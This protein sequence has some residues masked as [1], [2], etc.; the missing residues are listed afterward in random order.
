MFTQPVFLSDVPKQL[1]WFSPLWIPIFGCSGF[2]LGLIFYYVLFAIKHSDQTLLGP[3][4]PES[5]TRFTAQ[6]I[7]NMSVYLGYCKCAKND[8]YFPNDFCYFCLV[9]CLVLCWII[10]L[11]PSSVHSTL[12][13][14]RVNLE[15]TEISYRAY[16]WLLKGDVECWQYKW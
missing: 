16:L 5:R 15:L 11:N 9:L 2:T 4:A 12:S 13:P 14:K 7:F 1:K 8:K 3:S 6:V 10:A